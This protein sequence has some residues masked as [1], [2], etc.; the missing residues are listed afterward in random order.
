MFYWPAIVTFH[1][2]Q[3]QELLRLCRIETK[4]P[5]VRRNSFHR[6]LFAAVRLFPCRSLNFSVHRH[7]LEKNGQFH[8]NK[9]N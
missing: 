1:F 4:F 8:N 6:N 3:R 5:D 9:N 2:K 7:V